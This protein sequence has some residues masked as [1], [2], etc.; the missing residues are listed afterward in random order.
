[1]DS[2][3]INDIDYSRIVKS[4]T[5]FGIKLDRFLQLRFSTYSLIK[6]DTCFFK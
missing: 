3:Y 2:K 1:M 6:Y 5:R 4:I